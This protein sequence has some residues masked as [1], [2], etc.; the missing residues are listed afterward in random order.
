MLFFYFKGGD[1]LA[2]RIK[3]INDRHRRFCQEYLK[4]FNA[5]RAYKETYKTKNDKTAAS[6]GA[7][8]LR[9]AKVRAYLADMMQETK[10]KDILD[11][12]EVLTNLSEL[13]LGKSRDK[14]FKR[15]DYKGKKPKV[16][17]D[18]VTTQTP[19]DQDQLKAL[20]LLGKYYKIFTDKK[21]VSSELNINVGMGDYD[22]KD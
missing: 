3:K 17:Y 5:T 10:A 22:D 6:N 4:D 2:E 7:K 9:N 18:T 16:V 1:E 21:E 11:I 14:V 15:V 19:E 13:A 8:L 12:N 20:E